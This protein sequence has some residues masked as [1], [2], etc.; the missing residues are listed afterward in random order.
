[1]TTKKKNNYKVFPAPVD[2]VE[3][4]SEVT[5]ADGKNAAAVALGRKGGSS[6]SPRKLKAI[7]ENAKLA[8]KARKRNAKARRKLVEKEQAQTKV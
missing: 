8:T 7:L 6:L 1:M 3:Q 5:T 2:V 4:L